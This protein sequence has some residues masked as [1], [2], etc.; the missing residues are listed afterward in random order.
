[1]S[2]RCLGHAVLLHGDVVGLQQVL[3]NVLNNAAD[4]CLMRDNS[5]PINHEINIQSHYSDDRLILTITDNGIGLT[6]TNDELQNAFFTT[7]KDGLGLGL[8]ICRDVVEAH[9][10][11]FSLT[12]AQPMGCCVRI[13][14]PLLLP[15]Q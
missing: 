15:L 3:L 13:H 9:H 4:A 6:A 10:G 5:V 12:P 14:L 7:K 1:M 2:R 11:Q 8:A